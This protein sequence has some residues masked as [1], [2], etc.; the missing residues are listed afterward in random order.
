MSV[1]VVN[2]QTVYQVGETLS[3]KI[4]ARDANGRPKSHGEDFLLTKLHTESP[5]E[6]C[7]SGKITDHGD[8]TYVATFLLPL[9]GSFSVS[10][11]LIHPSE[12]IQ[13]LKR[14]HDI[15]SDR[16]NTWC[17]FYD[18]K[19]KIKEWTRCIFYPNYKVDP[20]EV[21]DFSKP[22]P[23]ATWYCGKPKGIACETIMKCKNNKTADH[24][25]VDSGKLVSPDEAQLFNIS[26]VNKEIPNNIRIT[27]KNK[28]SQYGPRKLEGLPLPTCGPHL[29]KTKSEGYWYNKTWTSLRCQ[30]SHFS[31]SP[32]TYRC[33]ENKTFY[34]FGD[35]TARQY[36]DY[37]NKLVDKMNVQL[38]NDVKETEDIHDSIKVNFTLHNYPRTHPTRNAMSEKYAVDII[39]GLVG[40]P[41]V[42]IIFGIWAH[43]A[44]VHIET[45]RARV[46]GIR[47]AVERLHAKYPETKV[48]WRTSNMRE[49]ESLLYYLFY[50]NWYAYQI[51]LEAK[52]ILGGLN[53][54]VMDVWEMSVCTGY[55]LHPVPNVI[56]NHFDLVFSYICRE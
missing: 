22:A 12:A 49:H 26:R 40:G 11:I 4:V 38:P 13:L 56:K 7:T 9:S 23:N 14:I 3:L 29:P 47:N 48:I 15:Y 16:R 28:G 45:F 51:M 32:S 17:Q 21:C 20:E 2:P 25:L 41:D 46:Y 19:A 39:D 18:R 53:I 44:A 43:Y 35:S 5:T 30:A 50:N 55:E 36:R 42:V 31:S 10:V 8:G 6:A 33:M 52:R 34:V 37:L 54:Y 27:I 24:A 1:S